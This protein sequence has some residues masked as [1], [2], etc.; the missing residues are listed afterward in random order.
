M[1]LLESINEFNV[2]IDILNFGIYGKQN[3]KGN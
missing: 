2:N 1:V 3:E